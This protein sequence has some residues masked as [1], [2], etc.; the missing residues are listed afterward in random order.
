MN[1]LDQRVIVTGAASGFGAAIAQR[2]A[3]DGFA[4]VADAVG[5]DR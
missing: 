4:N 2:L 1:L 3:K 5:A